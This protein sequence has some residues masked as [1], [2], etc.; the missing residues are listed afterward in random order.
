MAEVSADTSP[1]DLRQRNLDAVLEVVAGAAVPYFC[2]PSD[3]TR[4]VV[5]VRTPRPEDLLRLLAEA[6]EL[7]AARVEPIQ[8]PL[9]GM[10]GVRVYHAVTDPAGD[11]TV[12]A[13]H[14]CELE[15]WRRQ[16]DRLVG[17]RANPSGAALPADDPTVVAP[18]WVLSGH[19]PVSPDTPRVRTRAALARI[20]IDRVT[21]AVDAV[22]TWVDGD[23]PRWRERM[24]AARD[25]HQTVRDDAVGPQR[26]TDRGELRHSLRSLAYFAPW[27][28]RIY[29][30]TDDQVPD[31]L[32][33]AHP[34]V[35]VISH[36][37]IFGEAGRLPT[38]NSHAIESRLHHIP[39]LAEHFLYLNDDMFLGRPL[40]P[41]AF[42]HANGVAKFFASPAR[43]GLG[44]AAGY[45][46]LAAAAGRNGAEVIAQRFG[47]T[48]TDG[49]IPAPYPCQRSV[50]EEIE[51]AAEARMEATAGHRFR[52]PG[53]L[54]TLSSLQ[55][56][57]AFMQARAVPGQIVH[58]YVDT[59]RPVAALQLS[60]LLR[61]RGADVFCLDDTGPHG[62]EEAERRAMLR[63]F[64]GSYFPFRAPWEVGEDRVAGAEPPTGPAAERITEP[65]A[66]AAPAARQPEE[67]LAEPV[68]E[69]SEAQASFA[70][71]MISPL[72][73]S[74]SSWW[75]KWP[76]L[77]IRRHS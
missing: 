60:R 6:P 53:D 52:D 27:L 73:M 77:G 21:F 11:W 16:G 31:W 41:T 38:F 14:A 13:D 39:G 62:P 8:T 40:A 19:V 25:A 42:F 29:L 2:L 4:T 50:L 71:R 66:A 35:T 68:G 30:V 15:F 32:D 34:R 56:H 46:D 28:R 59:A 43:F 18:S 12:G 22:Y 44:P 65:V 37:E 1:A 9:G 55:H 70:Q 74:G 63:D 64:L 48:V 67:P 49:A 26:F 3:D 5:G 47:R 17:P 24:T 69:G 75:R 51:S 54:A 36:R 72:T 58:E 61:R 20:P 33:A 7:A 57:W 23:D 76:A 45:D 10:V